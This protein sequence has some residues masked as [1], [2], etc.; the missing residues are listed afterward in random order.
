MALRVAAIDEDISTRDTVGAAA[1]TMLVVSGT[2]RGL[3]ESGGVVAS[4]ELKRIQP[5]VER[6]TKSGMPEC[7]SASRSFFVLTRS[8]HDR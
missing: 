3:A 5:N 7:R 6:S 8:Q 2:M 4:V 1:V